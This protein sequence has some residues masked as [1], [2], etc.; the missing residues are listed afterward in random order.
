MTI[1]STLK[2]LSC[3]IARRAGGIRRRPAEGAIRKIWDCADW[4]QHS[5]TSVRICALVV[6]S[7]AAL[8]LLQSHPDSRVA[9]G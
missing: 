7:R 3:R 2:Q 9:G 8:E 1:E 5:M 4:D 6:T